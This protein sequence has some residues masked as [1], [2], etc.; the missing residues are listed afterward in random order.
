[1]KKN[2]SILLIL[3]ILFNTIIALPATYANSV[4]EEE[5]VWQ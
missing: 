1:M 4:P 2:I 3:T 5:L